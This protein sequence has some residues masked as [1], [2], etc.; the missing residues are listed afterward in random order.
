MKE[1]Y[2][3]KDVD[4]NKKIDKKSVF[5]TSNALKFVFE[6]KRDNKTDKI[7]KTDNRNT[8]KLIKCAGVFALV[9]VLIITAGCI[10]SG[11]N[12]DNKNN[13]TL[14]SDEKFLEEDFMNKTALFDNYWILTSFYDSDL[15]KK[16]I[17]E[18]VS[19]T[20][21]ADEEMFYGNSGC[22]SFSMEYEITDDK[23]IPGLYTT[24][25][26]RALDDNVAYTESVFKKNLQNI[27]VFKCNED[28]L[29]F[30]DNK[31]MEIL[32]FE[33][34]SIKDYEWKLDSMFSN[35][36]LRKSPENIS[37]TLLFD[38]DTAGGNSGCNRYFMSLTEVNDIKTFKEISFSGIGSTKMHCTKEGVMETESAYLGHLEDVKYYRITGDNLKFMDENNTCI[39]SFL[40]ITER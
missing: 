2:I 7:K 34:F 28:T 19:V 32:I 5:K 16:V 17:A 4:T 26:M 25:M 21:S 9:I 38:N 30:F 27:S 37:V 12:N 3:L 14:I 22:N 18:N 10:E 11:S 24:T 33:K 20:I 15:N 31:N 23:I 6:N 40:K 39:L 35:E 1:K 36:S 29:A 8:S 13:E